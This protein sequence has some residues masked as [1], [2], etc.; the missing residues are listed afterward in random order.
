MMANKVTVENETG[1]TGEFEQT[2][3]YTT[4]IR[5]LDRSAS[6]IELPTNPPGHRRRVQ[7]NWTERGAVGSPSDSLDWEQSAPDEESFE[8][9]LQATA[10]TLDGPSP[11]ELWSM[12][13]TLENWAVEPARTTGQPTRV[14]F[15][16]GT[17]VTTGV[18]TIVETDVRETTMKGYPRTVRLS[19]T[20][21]E[22]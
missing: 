8:L 21:R 5:P 7:A 15:Q 11:A 19:L 12:L 13:K 22:Q 18:M 14:V 16:R 1:F 10:P 3:P 2:S 9:L 4:K 6:A 20:I 17:S